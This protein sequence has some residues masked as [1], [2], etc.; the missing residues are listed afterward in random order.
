MP[1]MCRNSPHSV[2]EPDLPSPLLLLPA[3]PLPE[4]EE[5]TQEEEGEEKKDEEGAVEPAPVAGT[6][7]S[8]RTRG[9]RV[10][11]SE[12]RGRKS[13]PTCIE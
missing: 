1:G 7:M 3:A 5:G 11:M 4:G 10:T 12:P 9:R 13:R 8:W 6:L 2:E